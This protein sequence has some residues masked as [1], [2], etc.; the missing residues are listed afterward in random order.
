MKW[1]EYRTAD[2]IAYLTLN[3]PDKRNALNSAMVGELQ[4]ALEQAA[5]DADA[6]VIVL[7][8]NGPAFCA[9]ADLDYLQQLQGNSYE[10]NL[11]DSKQLAT[12]FETIYT[13]PK[14]V[15][16]QIQ[17]HAIAGGCGLAAVCDFSFSVP[18]A[19]FG[20]TEVKIGFVPAIVSY[21]LSR[22][23]GE[24]KARELLLTGNLI[25]ATQAQQYGMV[26]FIA[27][28]D[29][30]EQQVRDFARMLCQ[31]NSAQSMAQ[32]K[33]IVSEITA[34]PLAEAMDYAAQANAQARAT[35]D[36]RQGIAAFL[37]KQTPEW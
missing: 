14:V 9:G 10:D 11:L 13:L 29:E 36:C 3:R 7:K 21:F 23:I 22:K 8:A 5:A 18:E 35:A 15:I 34:K 31:Q 33:K 32:T 24:G 37:N 17:G 19:K 26:N 20:Y 30:I 12:L 2:R 6:K 28:A 4:A 1:I 25:S 27:A 16:A